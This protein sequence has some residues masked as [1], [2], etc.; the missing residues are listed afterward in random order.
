MRYNALME[1]GMNVDKIVLCLQIGLPL[2]LDVF[3][4][5]A[6]VMCWIGLDSLQEWMRRRERK[7]H[8]N[9]TTR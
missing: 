4:I 5:A 9:R 7:R 3:V 6:C 8:E 2:L 1:D